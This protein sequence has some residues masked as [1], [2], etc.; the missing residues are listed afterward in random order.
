MR[1][2]PLLCNKATLKPMKNFA[3]S[4][5]LFQTSGFLTPRLLN[6]VET[7]HLFLL[8]CVCRNFRQTELNEHLRMKLDTSKVS[9]LTFYSQS[10]L[11]A[12][13]IDDAV[14]SCHYLKDAAILYLKNNK[15]LGTTDMFSNFHII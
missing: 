3:I 11:K 1:Y 10:Y 13:T 5:F 7:L 2:R 12:A 4:R 9:L 14:S 8:I 6:T 15:L